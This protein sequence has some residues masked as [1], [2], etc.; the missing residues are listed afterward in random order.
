METI[1]NG[2]G[3]IFSQLPVVIVWV[4]GIIVALVTWRKHPRA[5]M[6]TLIAMLIFILAWIIDLVVNVF[7]PMGL[8]ASFGMP[9]QNIGTVV[10]IAEA[11]ISLFEVIGWGLLLVA[12][13]WRRLEPP[14]APVPAT[15]PAEPPLPPQVG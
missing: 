10:T 5:S 4:V 6:L 9:F 3:V 12:V 13:F 1:L 14:V 7:L 15:P 11:L 2:F 8:H